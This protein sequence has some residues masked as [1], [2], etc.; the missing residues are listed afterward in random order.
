VNIEDT[1]FAGAV[2][3]RI[4]KHFSINCDSSQMAATMYN[5]AKEDLFEFMKSKNASH[6]NRLSGFGL[7]KDIRYCLTPDIANV[8][9]IYN[10]GKLVV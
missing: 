7:D 10:D 9:V 2:I 6:Y 5:D 3:D 1:L 8:L 4:G